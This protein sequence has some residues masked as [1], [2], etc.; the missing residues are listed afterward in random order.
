[1]P[2]RSQ[3]SYS[4]PPRVAAAAGRTPPSG[5]GRPFGRPRAASP[6][7]DRR[8]DRR[9]DHRR[10]SRK[11]SR[12]SRSRRRRGTSSGR[13]VSRAHA[14]SVRVARASRSQRSKRPA[15]ACRARAGSWSRFPVARRG[16][17]EVRRG[18]GGRIRAVTRDGGG[19]GLARDARDRPSGGAPHASSRGRKERSRR[20]GEH[21]ATR[22]LSRGARTDLKTWHTIFAEGFVPTD[23]QTRVARRFRRTRPI[24]DCFPTSVIVRLGAG[25]P[26]ARHG[27]GLRPREGARRYVDPRADRQGSH[28]QPPPPG[29]RRKR[30]R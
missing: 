1:M 5:R 22:H 18:A 3:H 27:D 24:L 4:P 15:P 11:R 16:R 30:P 7:R 2:H 10:A 6:R 14:R 28:G 29:P 19:G 13:R 12:R 17:E 8:L 20:L 9:L 25:S 23:R 21:G 26:P